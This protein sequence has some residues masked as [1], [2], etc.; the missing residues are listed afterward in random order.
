MNTKRFPTL[1]A[2]LRA[3]TLAVLALAST[4]LLLVAVPV[5]TWMM[6][7]AKVEEGQLR[8]A[9]AARTIGPALHAGDAAA[10]TAALTLMAA[11]DDVISLAAYGPDGRLLAGG[12]QAAPVLAAEAGYRWSWRALDIVAPVT[13]GSLPAG[14]LALSLDLSPLHHRGLLSLILIGA[15][16]ALAVML[17]L[18]LQRRLVEGLVRPLRA[19]TG[20]MA[21]VS[22]GRHDVHAFGGG[23]DELDQL[24]AGFNT[25]VGQIRERDHW[26]TSHLSNLE[27]SVELRTR[28]LRQAKEAAEAGSRAKSEFLATMSH[29]IRTPMN[30]VLGMAELLLATP[31]REDQR[32]YAQGVERSGRHLLAIIND[33]L[34]FSKIES[35]RLPLESTDLEL[36]A[37]V[38]ELAAVPAAQAAEKGLG[39]RLNLPETPLPVR[40]DALRLRQVVLNL[41]SNALKFTASGE[42]SLMLKAAP[43][44]DGRQAITLA[45]RDTGIGIDPSLHEK[46][47]EQF[48]QG[49]GSTARK[50]GGTGLGLAISRRLVD[51]MGG[52]LTLESTPGQGACFTVS[53]DL[54]LGNTLPAQANAAPVAAS[55]GRFRGRVLVAED[56]ESNGIVV[57]THLERLGVTV[58]MVCDGEQALAAMAAGQFDLVLMDCQMP[59]IDGYAATRRW[60]QQETQGARLPIVALTANAMIGDRERCLEAGMDDYLAKPF[61]GDQ[62]LALLGRWLPVERRR[63]V[64]ESAVSPV[65][66][67]PVQADR[68]TEASPLD[69]A[70][71][72]KL[73]A[74]SPHGAAQLIRQLLEAFMRGALPLMAQLDE[75]RTAGDGVALARIGHALKS[76]SFNVGA[77]GLS[78]CGRQLEM[79]AR[80]GEAEGWGAACDALHREWQRVEAAI[81]T[82]LEQP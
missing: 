34:D 51:L 47:F 57:R 21:E 72:D 10:C 26:L 63:P 1:P 42:I 62:L 54:P 74:L 13:H 44:V 71:L 75:A 64:A 31:L 69:P 43:A 66:A 6:A 11:A 49:D 28:E 37:L 19:L 50:Y 16:V 56:N 25:M 23:I 53:L 45:V 76:S 9:L 27:Q 39:W 15:G 35:G 29:E 77:V 14:W 38:R 41:L 70:A 59:G 24:A 32:Q 65:L 52:R 40:G 58:E 55:S 17:G 8:L 80:A 60:R 12:G 67:A 30:G 48:S 22:V 78:E 68:A 82:Q 33:I 36:V 79:M 2:R 4:L 73:R 18:H 81:Q 46:I 61:S 7:S 5:A 20:H 3:I